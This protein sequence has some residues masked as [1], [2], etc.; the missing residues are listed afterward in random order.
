MSYY[1][2]L[3][4]AD[5]VFITKLTAADDSY[6][7]YGFFDVSTGNR[8]GQPNNQDAVKI[9]YKR[10]GAATAAVSTV[11]IRSVTVATSDGDRDGVIDRNDAFP[12]DPF[13][14]ADADGDGVGDNADA[15]PGLDDTVFASIHTAAQNA[16]D[17]AFS[18]YVTDNA[19]SYSYS[20]GGGDITQEAYDAVVA[21]KNAAE[22]LKPQQRRH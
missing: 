2:S 3:D 8:W 19:D 11:G 4:G 22:Q 13:E 6:I 15:Y 10:Y 17:A 14:S 16:G 18:T 20:V 12:A 7:G 9:S 1:Y 21:E 5:P